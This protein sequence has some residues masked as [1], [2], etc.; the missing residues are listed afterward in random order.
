[1]SLPARQS[2]K[3]NHSRGGGGEAIFICCQKVD[4]GLAAR[5]FIDTL[6]QAKAPLADRANGA[7][8]GPMRRLLVKSPH[9]PRFG[10]ESA[11]DELVRVADVLELVRVEL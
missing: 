11:Q 8:N 6:R 4:E 9:D 1:M 10:A 2:G 7:G 3:G 5:Q